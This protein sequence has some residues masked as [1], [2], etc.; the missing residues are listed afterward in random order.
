MMSVKDL[1]DAELAREMEKVKRELVEGED[2]LARSDAQVR[3]IIL[4]AERNHR[5]LFSI[6]ED[7]SAGS[8]P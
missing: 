1:T 3:S 2:T 4:E 7:D 8:N 6:D 5:L